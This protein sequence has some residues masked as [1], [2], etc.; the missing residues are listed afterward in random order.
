[1]TEKFKVTFLS[2]ALTFMD[3]LDRK[4]QEKIYYIIG[5]AQAINDPV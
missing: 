1:M 2:E 5:K 3:I 4:A